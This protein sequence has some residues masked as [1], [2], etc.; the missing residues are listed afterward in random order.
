MDR[1]PDRRRQGLRA[2][3]NACVLAACITS[4]QPDGEHGLVTTRP[5][6][7][8]A[9]RANGCGMG[10]QTTQLAAR[11]L[12]S[13]AA[14]AI[15]GG[16]EQTYVQTAS[17]RAAVENVL[18]V[19]GGI[20]EIVDPVREAS[21]ICGEARD[22]D[23]ESGGDSVQG[24]VGRDWLRGPGGGATASPAGG[25]PADAWRRLHAGTED[26]AAVVGEPVASIVQA[27]LKVP[28]GE[29]DDLLDALLQEWE[30]RQAAVDL[31]AEGGVAMRGDPARSDSVGNQHEEIGAVNEEEDQ[32]LLSMTF[33]YPPFFSHP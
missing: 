4:A 25:S 6:K 11:P 14:L 28:E 26:A 17:S 22:S 18:R 33:T 2:V 24:L 31:E 16:G 27:L 19:R 12:D 3:L 7:T 21:R 1:Q 23:E 15:T 5:V 9:S 13:A 32:E 20:T 29:R 30:D 10:P 8:P